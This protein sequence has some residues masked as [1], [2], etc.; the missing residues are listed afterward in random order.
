MAD[1]DKDLDLTPEEES[2][3]VTFVDEDGT[4]LTFEFLDSIMYQD[5]EY[6][7]MLPAKEGSSEVVILEVEPIDEENESYLT[8]E[9]PAILEAVFAVF[10]EHYKDVYTFES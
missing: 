10:K 9:D 3:L 4:E 2:N 6:L 8:V 7:V 1:K 5:K